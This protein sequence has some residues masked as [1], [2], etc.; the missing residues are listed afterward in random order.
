MVRKH[1]KPLEQVINRYQEIITFNEPKLNDESLNGKIVYKTL[2]SNGPL[3]EYFTAPQ[4]QI[5]IKNNIKINIKS[6]SDCYI[7]FNDNEDE[8]S[9]FKIINICYDTNI[10][11]NVVLA[12]KFNKTICYFEKPINSLKLGIA[13]VDELS[14][15]FTA[16]DIEFTNFSKY[17]LLVD[18]NNEQI[19]YPILHTN[20]V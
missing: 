4:F 16:I 2:H 11:K 5:F 14:E 19:A 8:L 7:G 20:D 15:N 17:M 12:K 10:S 6:K 18:K 9:I 1:K 13:I 3:F